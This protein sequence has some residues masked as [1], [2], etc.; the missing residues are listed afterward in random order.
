MHASY[1]SSTAAHVSSMFELGLVGAAPISRMYLMVLFTLAFRNACIRKLF[2]NVL[3]I[4]FSLTLNEVYWPFIGFF[5]LFV[6]LLHLLC[7]DVGH[8][9]LQ[10]LMLVAASLNRALVHLNNLKDHYNQ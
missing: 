6:V 5:C 7:S 8:H 9:F 2:V 4:Y 10:D 3:A 1:A